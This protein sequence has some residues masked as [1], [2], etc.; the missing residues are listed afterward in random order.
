MAETTASPFASWRQFAGW[1]T[2]SAH[3]DAVTF[4]RGRLLAAV[5]LI[6][7]LVQIGWQVAVWGFGFGGPEAQ[8][9]LLAIPRAV[10]FFV[11]WL[12]VFL[13]NRRGLSQIAGTALAVLLLGVT[14]VLVAE[15]GPLA[16]TA[17]ML[18]LP[19]VVAGFFGPPL[20]AVIIALLA[21]AGYL[22]LNLT[23]DPAYFSKMGSGGATSQT[24]LVYANLLF[25]AVMSWLVSQ[26]TGQTLKE[27]RELSLALVS[28]RQELEDRLQNQTRQLMATATV[29]RSIAGS[30]DVGK[31]LEDIVRLV[32][33]TFGYYHVQ[34]FLVDPDTP[35]AV[36]RQSTGDAGQA[37]VARGYRQPIGGVGVIGQV[38]ATGRGSI[39]K[40]AD[41]DF[42]SKRNELLP[43]TRSEM[44]VPLSIGD[45]IIGALDMQSDSGASFNEENMAIFQAL[46]DQLAIAI[47]NARLFE[48]AEENLRVMR[49]LNRE[50]TGRSWADFLAEAR[51]E[52]KHF[53][54]GPETKAME[55]H[56]SRVIERVLNTGGTIVS[57]GRDGRQAFIAA[58][59]VV[60]NEVVGVLGVEPDTAREWGPDDL[61]I[62]QSIAERTALAV[63]NAR[64]YIQAQRA[65]ER[66]ILINSIASRLQRAPNLAMLLESAAK[67]LA[68]ALGTANVYAEISMDQP[69][70]QTRK[71][72]AEPEAVAPEDGDNSEP[73]APAEP[74][75]SAEPENGDKGA[76]AATDQVPETTDPSEEARA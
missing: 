38:T 71:D 11:L 59:V 57:T 56:R 70:G 60:R 28:Q 55:I 41:G 27:S 26:L 69:L 39:S 17:L 19:V 16:P 44:A 63:E 58:P 42:L 6:I 20:S 30:R 33:E 47:E 4:R 23:A 61:Q 29:A 64:L 2:H 67:E 49:E 22:A 52:D 10:I 66:E 21:G 24:L 43:N 3:S 18:T 53:A 51:D 15:S 34:V 62:I 13:I 37:L 45:R 12:I 1:L 50:A 31:L 32:R 54:H 7:G 65:A 8:D 68:D 9:D 74:A 48:Q 14:L 40:E 25:I 35:Y 76:P 75:V 73:A 36:L 46:A 5:L 72:V